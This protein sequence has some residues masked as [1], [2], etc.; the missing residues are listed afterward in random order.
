MAVERG[1]DMGA[2]AALANMGYAA[3]LPRSLSMMSVLGLYV[4]QLTHLTIH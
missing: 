4:R 1:H 3:E 2:D